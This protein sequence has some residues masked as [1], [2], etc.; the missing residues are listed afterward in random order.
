LGPAVLLCLVLAACGGAT[1]TS[2]TVRVT[3]LDDFK[4]DPAKVEVTEGETIKFVVVNQ[5]QNEHEF[6]IGDEQTQQ[7]Y[8]ESMDDANHGEHGMDVTGVSVEP[9][10][11]E[12][13]EFVVPKPAGKLLYGC[14]VTGHYRS[15]MRG[16]LV[17]STA[18][19]TR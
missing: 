17:Y 2:R 13:F 19:S 5:G 16:E 1:S 14:H 7:E 12:S 4:Y 9:G 11:Q 3:M 6:L 8:E 18:S 10:A 15:G